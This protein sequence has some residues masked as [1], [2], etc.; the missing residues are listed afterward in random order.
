MMRGKSPRSD[1][2][3]TKKIFSWRP[4]WLFDGHFLINFDQTSLLNKFCSLRSIQMSIFLKLFQKNPFLPF[5]YIFQRAVTQSK[6]VRLTRFF[7]LHVQNNPM[8]FFLFWSLITFY[9]SWSENV[10]KM[11]FVA[12]ILNFWRPSWIDNEEILTLYSIH[13]NEHL[14]QFW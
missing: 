1:V 4:S 3:M 7:F 2:E 5:I 12:A 13:H 6:I 11:N 8:I 9:K 14:Y 10:K